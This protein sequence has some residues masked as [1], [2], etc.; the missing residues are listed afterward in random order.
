MRCHLLTYEPYPR[1]AVSAL[2]VLRDR[3]TRPGGVAEAM[4][5]AEGGSTVVIPAVRCVVG[6]SSVFR[7]CARSDS[8]RLIKSGVRATKYVRTYDVGGVTSVASP[9]DEICP[10]RRSSE[11]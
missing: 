4:R 2:I 5:S 11:W 3:R 6:C 7:Q 8:S 10:A 9:R 1:I